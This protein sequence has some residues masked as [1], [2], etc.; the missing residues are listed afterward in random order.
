MAR[1]RRQAAGGRYRGRASSREAPG[2]RHA[3]TR[4]RPLR[5]P[6]G[7][8]AWDRSAVRTSYPPASGG[9]LIILET[10]GRRQGGQR[11]RELSQLSAE[12]LMVG[13]RASLNQE[14]P[15]F[16]FFASASTSTVRASV[17]KRERRVF[18]R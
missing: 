15:R 13:K 8:P 9:W 11:P 2:T 3:P 12:W 7:C 10:N 4:T 1:L 17:P 14:N 5:V 18:R 16:E 6:R